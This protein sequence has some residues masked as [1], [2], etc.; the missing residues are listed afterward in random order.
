VSGSSIFISIIRVL[1]DPVAH[2]FQNALARP[3]MRAGSERVAEFK[4][5]A[6]Q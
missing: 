5:F 6:G 2:R 4:P 3:E 1:P